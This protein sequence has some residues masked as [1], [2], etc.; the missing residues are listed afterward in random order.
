MSL[1]ET[2]DLM[3]LVNL[4]LSLTIVGVSLWG[5][6]RIGKPTPLYFGA[7]YVLFSL[8]HAILLADIRDG[9]AIELILMRTAG[10]LLVAIGLFALLQD[11]LGRK[12]AEEALRESEKHLGATFAQTAVGIME[13]LPRGEIC[14]YNRKFF[15][16]L[17]GDAKEWLARSVW[18]MIE[19]DDDPV[20]YE[21]VNA[22]IRGE[23]AEYSD[24][25]LLRRTDGKR[26]WC[27]F[28][29]STVRSD[30]GTLKYCIV[31]VADI[32]ERKRAEAELAD[33]NASLEERVLERTLEIAKANDRL[34]EEIDQRSNAEERLKT[35][36]LEKDVLIREI[37]HRVKNNLQI[38]I[39]LLSLQ[40]QQSRD[41]SS[42]SAL[43]DSQTRVRS[44]AL[45]HEKL[46]QS[47]NL[48]SIDFQAYIQNLVDNLMVSYGVD[49]RRILVTVSARDLPLT[50]NT[51]IPL[52]LVMN[53]LVSNALKY[54]F[55]EGR[56]G[57]LSITGRVD[58]KQL[59]IRIR[60]D[61]VGIPEAFDWR[62]AK[63]LGLH[64]VQLL[65]R[66][67]DGTIELVR[68]S[69]SE[70]ILLIPLNGGE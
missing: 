6:R 70:F 21:A 27:Q 52:G 65:T 30:E 23:R 40:A 10:Y 44:M 35:S 53:E 14:R 17:G 37:H 60:D 28:S 61:G 43:M 63:S 7:A 51:A 20:K 11:I 56:P 57:H 48:S 54:A 47:Q 58:G 19:A 34:V 3:L 46:Y 29:L 31:V 41:T 33:L 55:T 1:P 5:Y 4:I 45:I 68:D 2:T 64:L 13:F 24:E 15:D 42:A 32:S 59:Q 66:Q 18:D 67:L 69:G 62:N 50:I 9:L 49:R 39:S 38:I 12:L 36:L 26:V 22:V 16:I 25:M 8:S